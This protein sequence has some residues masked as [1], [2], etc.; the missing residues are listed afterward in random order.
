MGLPVLTR[1][2]RTFASRMAGS[3]LN[4][5]NLPELITTNIGDYEEQAVHLATNSK[6]YT[7]LKRRL[8]DGRKTSPLFDVPSFVR[9]F[10]D[11]VSSV[12][13]KSV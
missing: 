8:A 11:A 1:S 5:L 9:D 12:L 10:E 2:G 6:K 3:L 13:I 4:S 7:K